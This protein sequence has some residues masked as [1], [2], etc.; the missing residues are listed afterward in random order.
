MSMSYVA[1]I[2]I[3]GF[4][5]PAVVIAIA[6]IATCFNIQQVSNKNFSDLINKKFFTYP[7]YFHYN[8]LCNFS[9]NSLLPQVKSKER[10]SNGTNEL[11]DSFL[12]LI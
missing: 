6:T 11:F 3:F 4:T 10:Y 2:L 8:T 9:Y 7:V 12:Q 5:L 1:W